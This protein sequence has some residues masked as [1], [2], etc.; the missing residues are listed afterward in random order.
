MVGWLVGCLLDWLVGLHGRLP[1]RTLACLL[2]FSCFGWS[3]FGARLVEQQKGNLTTPLFL[4]FNLFAVV[5]VEQA[6]LVLFLALF[7]CFTLLWFV[8]IACLFCLCL[9]CCVLLA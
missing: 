5:C 8:M 1:A 2:V 3:T 6:R 9:L 7:V 4:V